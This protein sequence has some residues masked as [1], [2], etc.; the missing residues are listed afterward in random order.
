MHREV[1]RPGERIFNV[2]AC[3]VHL[4]SLVQR[5]QTAKEPEAPAQ[6]IAGKTIDAE[7]R[8]EKTQ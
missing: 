6:Q 7:V 8:K 2:S 1:T 3:P 5:D 4:L